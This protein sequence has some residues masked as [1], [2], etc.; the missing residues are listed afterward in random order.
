LGGVGWT[1]QRRCLM[2]SCEWTAGLS[3][4]ERCNE[5]CEHCYIGR[6]NIWNEVGYIPKDLTREQVRKL[7]LQFQEVNVTRIN[8]GGGEAPLHPHFIEV[9]SELV[10][11]GIKV[12]LTT[13][14]STFPIIRRHLHL[15][16][17]IGVSL[18]LPTPEEHGKF[19][20]NLKA[21]QW[22]CHAVEELVK[23][24]IR[25]ELVTCIMSNNYD[26]LPEIYGLAQ[27]LGVDMWRLN[28]FHASQNDVTRLRA[29]SGLSER[30]LQM[31]TDLSCSPT[32]MQTAYEYLASVTP[33]DMN[34]AIPEPIFR[35]MVGGY[36]VT[37]G[38]PYGKISFR[39]KST[40]DVTP[41]VFTEHVAGNI[42]QQP[43]KD[44]LDSDLFR[45][46]R[47]RNPKGK[48]ET[49][50]NLSVC[51][52]G[53]LTDSYLL[54]GDLSFPDPFCFLNPNEERPT[55]HMPLSE[56]HHVHE[57]YLATIYV[58]IKGMRR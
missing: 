18:D 16:N 44:I 14:G 56:T 17:D 48:C 53:N 24:G 42:L 52:G 25:N 6:K 13:N 41:D 49:C 9:V 47:D 27:H 5:K 36:S 32:Q 50:V 46:F 12:S 40:G 1:I 10:K 29:V 23:A 15:F 34:Y 58:P 3:L 30:V 7:I 35:L 39:I 37:S 54:E 38:T 22:A 19:R 57:S 28:R 26:R 43:L 51:E 4:T 33:K 11:T 20:G 55:K 2:E 8:F 21:F 31:N 45:M